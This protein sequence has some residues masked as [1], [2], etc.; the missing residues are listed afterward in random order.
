[1]RERVAL[2]H[3]T[4]QHEQAEADRRGGQKNNPAEF[5]HQSTSAPLLLMR[6]LRRLEFGSRSAG[7]QTR[8]E[9]NDFAADP[10]TG[11]F[12]DDELAAGVAKAQT[13]VAILHECL[14]RI[15]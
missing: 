15:R 13:Q 7:Q 5:D 3:R 1:M 8:I 9:R 12:I 14:D 2:Q 10:R 6:P 4:K 11:K